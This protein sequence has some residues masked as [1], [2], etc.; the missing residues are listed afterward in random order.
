MKIK[1]IA[2]IEVPFYDYE[3]KKLNEKVKKNILRNIKNIILDNCNYIDLGEEVEDDCSRLTKI[4]VYTK[5]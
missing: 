3:T 4:K 1:I 2:E 5:S